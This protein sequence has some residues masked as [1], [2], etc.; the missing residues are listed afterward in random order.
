MMLRLIEKNF[1]ATL[2]V[3]ACLGFLSPPFFS[4]FAPYAHYFLMINLFLGFLKMDIEGL[5][6]VQ[7]DIL[8][9]GLRAL[10]SIVGVPIAVY[11]ITIPLPHEL[12]VGLFLLAAANCGATTPLFSGLL[13]F[14]VLRSGFFVLLT[15][16][17]V[18][19]VL[20][21]LFYLFFQSSIEI[22][23]LQ[24]SIY[25]AKVVVLPAVLGILFKRFVQVEMVEKVF[26]VS[27]WMGTVNLGIL[28]AAV[29]ADKHETIATYFFSSLTTIGLAAMFAVF[30]IKFFVGYALG[31]GEKQKWGDGLMFVVTNNSLMV[32]LAMQFFT[33]K[34]VWVAM[35]SYF[36]WIVSY[37]IIRWFRLK[38]V[39]I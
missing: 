4:V 16:I 15:G 27:P 20:P 6:T 13:G 14:D 28:L 10:I 35:L 32:L 33:P 38:N 21:F 9:I 17:G 31:K 24:M 22:D 30:T 1:A 19:F 18:V 5:K 29:V 39:F 25:L 12:K 37:P 36:P 2:F 34:E 8:P 7:K 3:F 11:F 26:S 23:R